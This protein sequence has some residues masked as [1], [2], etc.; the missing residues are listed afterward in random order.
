MTFAEGIFFELFLGR[1]KALKTESLW[2]CIQVHLVKR[3]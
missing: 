2:M 1:T 3:M